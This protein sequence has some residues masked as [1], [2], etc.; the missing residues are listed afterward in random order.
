[1]TYD[2]QHLYLLIVYFLSY[3]PCLLVKAV[4]WSSLSSVGLG[5][6]PPTFGG[7]WE[8]ILPRRYPAHH[9]WVEFS[10]VIQAQ[11]LFYTKAEESSMGQSWKGKFV[12][13]SFQRN[14][15]SEMNCGF[16][17]NLL[18]EISDWRYTIEKR[19]AIKSKRIASAM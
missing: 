16:Q 12:L 7:R 17:G 18:Q 1:M 8:S 19:A 4:T 5:N 10:K 6:I 9:L 3:L 13:S 14:G 15:V 2:S 11:S